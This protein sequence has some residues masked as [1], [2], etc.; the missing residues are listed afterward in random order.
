[1][2]IK[3]YLI[4]PDDI[5]P[6][7][8][9]YN[10]FLLVSEINSL[11][12]DMH[13][14]ADNIIELFSIRPGE[15]PEQSLMANPDKLCT[16]I[17]QSLR[18]AVVGRYKRGIWIG[19]EY[20]WEIVATENTIIKVLNVDDWCGNLVHDVVLDQTVSFLRRLTV[21]LST[22]A[23]MCLLLHGVA[24]PDSKYRSSTFGCFRHPVIDLQA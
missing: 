24:F 2:Y 9:L 18:E 11:I 21:V 14:C 3:Q 16:T 19:E 22:L 15:R 12:S 17:K 8:H 4:K 6:V 5:I 7:S 13:T 1:M 20:Y 10:I 23:H